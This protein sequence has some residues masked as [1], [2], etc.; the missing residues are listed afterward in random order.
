[1]GFPSAVSEDSCDLTVQYIPKL[2]H[3]LSLL[4]IWARSERNPQAST[5][6]RWL[7]SPSESGLC[8]FLVLATD[9]DVFPELAERVS[10]FL[11]L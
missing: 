3:D 5:P 8:V 1:M 7:T 10:S 6:S 11:V 9:I 4:A 2:S